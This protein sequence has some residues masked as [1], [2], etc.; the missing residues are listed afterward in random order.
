M[1]AK[2]AAMRGWLIVLVLA[3]LGGGSYLWYSGSD[4][5]PLALPNEE[6]RT[7][8]S[9]QLAD[10]LRGG[11]AELPG[12]A[13][14]GEAKGSDSKTFR[15]VVTVIAVDAETRRR[16]RGFE[17]Q[18]A[19]TGGETETI[20]VES[21]R[22]ELRLATGSYVLRAT[23][24]D[25]ESPGAAEFSITGSSPPVTIRL[26]FTP[27][28]AAL[29]LRV[30]DKANLLPLARFRATV[31]TFDGDAKQGLTEFLPDCRRQPLV[32]PAKVGQRL[33]VTIEA[34][35]FTPA[36]PVAVRFDGEQRKHQKQVVLAAQMKFAGIELRV[37]DIAQRV[38]P[39][40]NVVARALV[41]G[42]PDKIL[43]DRT[44]QAED[45]KYR[46]PDLKPG[47]YRLELCAIDE[48]HQ[49]TF[50]LPHSVTLEYFDGQH[51][52]EPIRLQP[53][54]MI[55]LRVTD[56]AG[57]AI[58]KDVWIELTHPDGQVR[59]SIWRP[60]L[61][62]KPDGHV[63]LGADKMTMDAPA[64]LHRCLPGGN[65]VLKLRWGRGQPVE[66]SVRIDGGRLNLVEVRLSR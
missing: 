26:P 33:V 48:A 25:C 19:R 60:I 20:P 32:L 61:A 31:V 9:D 24:P 46:L 11:R 6:S 42:Q 34:E 63:N 28:E 2:L 43:W 56:Q 47:R 64:R 39:R 37:T 44:R 49:P 8:E 51:I 45:G 21:D 1:R 10:P 12:V 36:E 59:E 18:L 22:H 4:S 7:V 58:G 66:R 27:F 41:P 50:H 57:R 5:D 23:R 13:E 52:I 30:V 53:G 14:A 29:H 16:L 40:L 55:E 15:S 17:I 65:Y 38:I 54:G 35:G 3:V 62:D